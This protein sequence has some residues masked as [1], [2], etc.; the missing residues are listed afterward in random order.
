MSVRVLVT[1][2]SGFVGRPLVEALARRG[3]TVIAASR[4]RPADTG[5]ADWIETD[6]LADDPAD[7]VAAARAERLV[8]L[9]WTAAPGVYATDLGNV[10][11]LAASVALGRAFLAA[12][13]RRI[14]GVGSCLE[15]DV[16][17]NGPKLLYGACK[18]A[19]RL[20]LDGLARQAPG[21]SFAWPRIFFLLGR[22]DYPSRLAPSLARRLTAG[23]PVEVSSGRVERDFMDVRDCA[24]AIA[25]LALTDASGC[26][27]IATG[28]ST[29]I[30][31]LAEMIALRSGRPDLL[32]T[33]PALDRPGE[34]ARIVGDAGA[35]VA[36]TGFA[37]RFSL[38][39]AI[40]DVLD[41]WRD[42]AGA[43]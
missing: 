41:H 39:A 14:V 4:R 22:H 10:D 40:D 2:A 36:A 28:V 30:H 42:Q 31:D 3:A 19:C 25:A 7:L 43:A 34:A 20:A 21:A 33:N 1:G 6:L 16:D 17:E 18:Q 32:R 24:D 13:G 5:A 26:F 37:P 27:D 23:E 12:G 38:E 15:Y 35:L 9:A 8:H 11:W 29:R